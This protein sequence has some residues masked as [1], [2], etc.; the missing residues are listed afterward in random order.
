MRREGIETSSRQP[1]GGILYARH[2]PLDTHTVSEPPRLP[3]E[4]DMSGRVPD[5]IVRSRVSNVIFRLIPADRALL[6]SCRAPSRMSAVRH[7][8]IAQSPTD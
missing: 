2:A 5:A 4:A 6:G 3:K 8:R 1:I 7:L